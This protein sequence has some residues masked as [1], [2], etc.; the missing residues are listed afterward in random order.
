MLSPQNSFFLGLC[1]TPSTLYPGERGRI[2]AW[3][4]CPPLDRGVVPLSSWDRGVVPLSLPYFGIGPFL[5][6]HCWLCI[7][8]ET[9]LMLAYDEN[10]STNM[11]LRDIFPLIFISW[12]SG[13]FTWDQAFKHSFLAL[14]ILKSPF[15]ARCCI[16][17]KDS[18]IE[19][20]IDSNIQ[21]HTSVSIN[22]ATTTSHEV[23]Y[24]SVFHLKLFASTFFHYLVNSKTGVWPKGKPLIPTHF[25]L[26]S[27]CSL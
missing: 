2:G 21:F 26:F 12:M 23:I 11:Y 6:L 5:G 19:E 22:I 3:N 27:M 16:Q 9:P 1:I 24:I 25:P 20:E 7:R 8:W 4:N 13:N 17:V 18:T 14:S 15:K 10:T